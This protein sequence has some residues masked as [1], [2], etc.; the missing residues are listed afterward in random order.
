MTKNQNKRRWYDTKFRALYVSLLSLFVFAGVV[1]VVHQEGIGI[2]Y[3]TSKSMPE[4]WYIS[5]PATKIKRGDTVLF[6]PSP[7]LDKYIAKRGW[8]KRDEP[9]MKRVYALPS[10]NVCMSGAWLAINGK[11]TVYRKAVDSKGRALPKLH[12]CRHLAHNEYLLLSKFS[13]RS[14][15]GRYFGPTTTQHIFAK[16]LKL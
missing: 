11:A 4:G 3:Q 15:D 2:I 16:V 6:Q 14:F 7:A 1:Y 8:K 13:P 10:D 5:Y 12:F 9:M